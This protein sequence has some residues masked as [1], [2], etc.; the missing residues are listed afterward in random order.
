MKRDASIF[1]VMSTYLQ[2]LGCSPLDLRC[3]SGLSNGY[4][5]VVDASAAN[6]ESRALPGKKKSSRKKVAAKKSSGNTRRKQTVIE[7]QDP[8]SSDSDSGI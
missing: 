4:H 2:G 7:Q 5:E 6:M 3:A 8:I 1:S